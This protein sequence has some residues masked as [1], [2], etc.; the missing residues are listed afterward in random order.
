[1][2]VQLAWMLVDVTRLLEIQTAED[3]TF[4][5]GGTEELAVQAEPKQMQ[6]AEDAEDAEGTGRP[7]GGPSEGHGF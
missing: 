3:F 7:G 5:H 4:H 6:T 2:L 1:M